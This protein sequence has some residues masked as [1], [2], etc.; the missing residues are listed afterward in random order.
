MATQALRSTS[1]LGIKVSLKLQDDF[2]EDANRVT[3]RAS[4]R[5]R[6]V[7]GVQVCCFQLKCDIHTN[8][9]HTHTPR[10]AAR[11]KGTLA[12]TYSSWGSR[13]KLSSNCRKVCVLFSSNLKGKGSSKAGTNLENRLSSTMGLP[14]GSHGLLLAHVITEGHENELGWTRC[15]STEI[16]ELRN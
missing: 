12:L 3:C 6:H 13:P 11:S 14:R 10:P 4:W 1:A 8:M 15:S 16:L 9:S 7:S 2:L 5:R